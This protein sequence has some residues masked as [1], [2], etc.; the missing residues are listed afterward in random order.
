[1]SFIKF[2]PCL[3]A[4]EEGEQRDT[5]AHHER[6]HGCEQNAETKAALKVYAG[7]Y[8]NTVG[9]ESTMNPA[10]PH[11]KGEGEPSDRTEQRA[12]EHPFRYPELATREQHAAV[13][14]HNERTKRRHDTHHEAG[15]APEPRPTKEGIKTAV[16]DF[17]ILV[18][19]HNFNLLEF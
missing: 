16:G 5:E 4:N 14:E 10:E 19:G 9:N 2:M 13:Q 3:P 17:N 15:E 18:D 11:S 12:V 6:A 1:M 7:R 8:E